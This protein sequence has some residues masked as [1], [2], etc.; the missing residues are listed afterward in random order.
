MR[1]VGSNIIPDSPALDLAGET[2]HA[3]NYILVEAGHLVVKIFIS[4]GPHKNR[5]QNKGDKED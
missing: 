3:N 5:A 2:V 1:H 4:G